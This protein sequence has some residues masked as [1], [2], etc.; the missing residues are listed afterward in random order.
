MQ[1]FQGSLFANNVPIS[2]GYEQ[3]LLSGACYVLHPS[4]EGIFAF[5]LHSGGFLGSLDIESTYLVRFSAATF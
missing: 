1:L 2:A 5:Y 4:F 3:S